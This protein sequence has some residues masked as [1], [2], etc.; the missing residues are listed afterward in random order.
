M[1]I[2]LFPSRPCSLAVSIPFTS[3]LTVVTILPFNF[4]PSII[5]CSH[6]PLLFS[7]PGALSSKPSTSSPS[8]LPWR[9]SSS[10]SPSAA[11][12]A[13]A[14]AALAAQAGREGGESERE[15]E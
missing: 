3:S 7:L 8:S 9:T 10:P 14:S 2:L 15:G 12:S 6:S 13:P 5:V 4:C 11:P 1:L